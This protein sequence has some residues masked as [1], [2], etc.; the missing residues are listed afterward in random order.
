MVYKAEDKNNGRVNKW[1]I[2]QFRRFIN[3]AALKEIHLNGR[4][5]TWS[6]ERVHP[7]LERID[8]TFISNEWED[9]F[10][11]NELHM[12]SSLCSDHAPLLLQTDASFTGKGRFH[13]MAFRPKCTCFMEVIERVWHYPLHNGNPLRRLDWLLRNTTRFLKR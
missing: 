5:F 4:L 11:A 8:I 12:L 1:L 7:T 6:N 10:P 2:G 9:L 3:E 13:F